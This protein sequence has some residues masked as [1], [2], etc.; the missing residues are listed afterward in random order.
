MFP[1]LNKGCVYIAVLSGKSDI[2]WDYRDMLYK[3]A[4]HNHFKIEVVLTKSKEALLQSIS[5]FS[6]KPDIIIVADPFS[7]YQY[8]TFIDRLERRRSRAKVF[9]LGTWEV[10]E[11]YEKLN[12]I[13]KRK[14]IGFY[15]KN[16]EV[17]EKGA[18]YKMNK[19][20]L[21]DSMSAKSGLTTRQSEKALNG[22]MNVIHTELSSGGN[23]QLVGFGVFRVADRKDRIARNPQT[24]EA[25]KIKGRKAPVFRAGSTLK[26]VVNGK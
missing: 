21:V 2:L 23:V 6:R 24:G 5:I 15:E 1:W 7:Q 20:Q 22:L 12:G 11:V 3:F 16:C 4:E 13:L 25:M 26:N 10:P 8:R 19:R 17:C 14:L 18:C 9:F